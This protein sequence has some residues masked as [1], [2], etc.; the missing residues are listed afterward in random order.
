MKRINGH[1]IALLAVSLSWCFAVLAGCQ[2]FGWSTQP[3][4]ELPPDKQAL[5]SVAAE[6]QR[7]GATGDKITDPGRPVAAASDPPPLTGMLGNVQAPI[8]GEIFT[9]VNA[10]AGW[11]DGTTYIQVWAGVSPSKPGR[12]YVFVGRHTGANGAIDHDVP[13]TTSL[14]AAPA[15]RSPLKILREDGGI[16]ILGT[17]DGLEFRFDPASATFDRSGS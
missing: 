13:P 16:L 6:H 7:E 11:V 17:P 2:A 1:P 5:E 14:V 15:G 9:P 8:F 10:W 3:T 4:D 12:G